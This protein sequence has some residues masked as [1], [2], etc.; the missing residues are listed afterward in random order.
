[1]KNIY[2]EDAE[3]SRKD[4][5]IRLVKDGKLKWLPIK[6]I[7][8]INCIGGCT[9][10][11]EF[12]SLASQNRISIHMYSYYGNYS[13]SFF[14]KK[15]NKN[16]KVLYNQS[17]YFEDLKISLS[18][19]VIYSLINNMLKYLDQYRKKKDEK[20][21]E[22]Y[23][24]ISSLLSLLENAK[25]INTIMGIEGKAW[26]YFYSF[27]QILYKDVGFNNRNKRPPKDM[28]NSMISFINTLLYNRIETVF[29]STD[30][31][32]EISFLHSTQ[33]KR[34]SLTLD[35]AE[36]YKVD[37][38]YRLISYL[39]RKKIVKQD[40][41][42]VVDG[43]CSGSSEVI[44]KIIKEF[45]NL[46]QK[47]FY[48]NSLKRTVTLEFSMKLESYK[49]IRSCMEGENYSPITLSELGLK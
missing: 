23:P 43:M 41:F 13:G 16:G 20:S 48:S 37:V 10:T 25:D 33:Q 8:E 29:S 9:F 44:K 3:L 12:L 30:I 6:K 1:M 5:T 22:I 39:V 18:K 32:T 46:M 28:I 19:S 38:T 35:I 31:Y 21:K 4:N 36:L 49:L 17:R 42:V 15:V 2:I 40:D 11:N 45:E 7:K 27:L 14:N 34:N 26:N 24:K 47:S